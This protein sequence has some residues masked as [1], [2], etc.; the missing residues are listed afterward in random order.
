M[1]ESGS[2]QK[3]YLHSAECLVSSFSCYISAAMLFAHL[4]EGLHTLCF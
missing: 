4:P 1:A 3:T 2:H